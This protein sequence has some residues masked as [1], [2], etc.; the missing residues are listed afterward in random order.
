MTTSSLALADTLRDEEPTPGGALGAGSE[1]GGR[2][3][4]VSSV[5]VTPTVT[6][7]PTD[8]RILTNGAELERWNA[9]NKLVSV[10]LLST[11]GATNSFLVRFSRRFDSRQVPDGRVMWKAMIEKYLNSF[12]Q[13]RRIMMPKLSG[14]VTKPNQDPEEYLT[15]MFQQWDKLEH[16]ARGSRRRAFW[17]SF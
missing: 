9:Y 15:E 14:I 13:R 2:H 10:L 4:E 11:K 12:I 3:E 5:T 1:G 6:A 17:I 16:T 8:K 7:P